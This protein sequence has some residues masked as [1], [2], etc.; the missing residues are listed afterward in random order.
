MLGR[1]KL[2][3]VEVTKETATPWW[4]P[5]TASEFQIPKD[6]VSSDFDKIMNI[7]WCK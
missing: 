7:Q 4:N 6:K 1:A 5:L 3:S 2:V